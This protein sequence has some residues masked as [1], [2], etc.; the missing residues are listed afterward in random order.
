MKRLTIPLI[1]ITI[2]LASLACGQSVTETKQPTVEVINEETTVTDPVIEDSNPT[3]IEEETNE[4]TETTIQTNSDVSLSEQVVFDQEGITI[5]VKGLDMED[6]FFGPE[7]TVLI[8]NGNEKDITVQVRDISINDVMVDAYFSSDVASGKK[9]N[10]GITIME[11]YLETANIQTIKTIEFSF[12]IFDSES[13]DTIIDSDPIVLTTLGS[14]S[15]VQEYDDSGTVAVDTNDVKI[16]IKKLDSEDSFW[17]TDVY[18][19]IE[20]NSDQNITI[21]VRDVSINGFMVDPIFSADVVAGKKAFDSIAFMESDLTDNDITEITS[22]EL[23]FHVF[24]MDNWDTIFD[25]EIVNI[26]FD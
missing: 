19:Y 16:V 1:I 20:N 4:E 6:S 17:G 14:E 24:N 15:Y 13:W 22:I 12:H 26:T 5:T 25:S 9:A 21:Q 10:D 3:E 2:I 11:D 7:I 8:E 23:K 18:V